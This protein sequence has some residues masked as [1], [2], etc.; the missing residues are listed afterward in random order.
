MT[1]AKR[2]QAY[3]PG[4]E[5]LVRQTLEAHRLLDEHIEI[6]PGGLGS[7]L[8]K[9]L[10][11]QV[12]HRDGIGSEE[13]WHFYKGTVK[14]RHY[15]LA[16]R[17]ARQKWQMYQFESGLKPDGLPQ[18]PWTG[19]ANGLSLDDFLKDWR[20]LWLDSEPPRIALSPYLPGQHHP[21]IWRDEESPEPHEV[22]LGLV[23]SESARVSRFLTGRLREAFRYIQPIPDDRHLQVYGHELR[24]LLILACTEVEA[25]WK[26][27]LV[28]NDISSVGERYTRN[29]Y[30]RLAEPMRLGEW[31]LVLSGYSHEIRLVPFEGWNPR[32][33][34]LTWYDAYNATK[35]DRE[36]KLTEATLKNVIDAMGAVF[37][38]QAAQFGPRLEDADEFTIAESPRWAL[39]ERY[40]S[41]RWQISKAQLAGGWRPTPLSFPAPIADRRRPRSGRQRARSSS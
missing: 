16:V 37:I 20:P 32:H 29:D 38:M 15:T 27:I 31:R 21:R 8:V 14:N 19:D 4:D 26:A 41:P 25:A 39:D 33:V 11:H 36:A 35:H 23:A 3:I 28:A 5:I 7:T 1:E 40:I 13:P 10:S 6:H 34:S 30:V 12:L 18:Q 9:G 22:G 17:R 24:E 2:V